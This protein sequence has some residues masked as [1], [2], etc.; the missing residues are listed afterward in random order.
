[1]ITPCVGGDLSRLQTIQTTSGVHTA[2]CLVGNG[3]LFSAMKS[4]PCEVGCWLL[5]DD[6]VKNDS[7]LGL[8]FHDGV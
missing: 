7:Y 8:R 5:S 3:V 1:M 6:E 4:R 2:S